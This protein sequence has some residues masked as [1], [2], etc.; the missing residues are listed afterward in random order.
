MSGHFVIYL[1]ANLSEACIPGQLWKLYTDSHQIPFFMYLSLEIQ[2]I[3]SRN[4]LFFLS[5]HTHLLSLANK[6][7]SSKSRIRPYTYA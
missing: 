2:G 6:S 5:P 1:E 7:A 3:M 4:S